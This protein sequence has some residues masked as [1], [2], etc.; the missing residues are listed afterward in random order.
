MDSAVKGIKLL[1]ICHI[2]TIVSWKLGKISENIQIYV[3]WWYH[4]VL[5]PNDTD[6]I[7]DYNNYALLTLSRLWD[8]FGSP[9]FSSQKLLD[10]LCLAS[11]ICR[12]Q[13][14][15]WIERR[16]THKSIGWLDVTKSKSYDWFSSAMLSQLALSSARAFQ[17]TR[18]TECNYI[19]KYFLNCY[20]MKILIICIINK[21]IKYTFLPQF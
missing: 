4:N 5:F 6:K 7:D 16:P 3:S 20:I 19:I 9:L 11:H 18:G 10:P 12:T 13:K 2:L 15:M 17:W 21:C 8:L 14:L 1:Q